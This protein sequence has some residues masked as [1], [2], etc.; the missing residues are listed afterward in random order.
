MV[1]FKAGKIPEHIIYQV[2]CDACDC[3]FGAERKEGLIRFDVNGSP[4][5]IEFMCPICG[6]LNQVRL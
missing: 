3:E 1:I 6:T 4:N 5:R 2:T